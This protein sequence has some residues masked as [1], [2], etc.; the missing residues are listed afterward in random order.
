MLKSEYPYKIF[1][2]KTVYFN[3]FRAFY[4]IKT[5][6]YVLILYFFMKL[7]YNIKAIDFYVKRQE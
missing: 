1:S 3:R 7:W 4:L 5:R 2:L 6:K